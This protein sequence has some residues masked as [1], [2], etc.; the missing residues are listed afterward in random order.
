MIVTRIKR[1]GNILKYIEKG[2]RIALLGCE[3]CAKDCGTSGEDILKE[4]KIKFQKYGFEV[5]GTLMIDGMCNRMLVKRD[6]KKLK[7]DSPDTI[8]CF[9][10]GSG[11]QVTASLFDGNTLTALDTI[12]LARKKRAGSFEESCI[13]CGAC[14]L[15]RT[16]GICPRTRC[17]KG[18]TNGPCGGSIDGRCEVDPDKECAWIQIYEKLRERGEQDILREPSS[19]LKNINEVRPRKD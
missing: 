13:M 17:A 15:N 3:I 18:I 19:P 16:H 12:Y 7:K 2:R 10:C 5:T 4:Y 6:L 14:V 8:V 9:S 1:D 11:T